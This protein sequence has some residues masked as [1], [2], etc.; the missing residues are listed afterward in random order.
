M[1]GLG[2]GIGPV[3]GGWLLEHFGWTAVFLVNVPIVVAVA[4]RR[5]RSWCPT[6]SD[7]SKARLDPLGAVLSTVGLGVLTAA[8]IEA[9]ERGW[10]AALVLG[11]L[12][13]GSRGARGL[14]GLGAPHARPRCSTCACSSVRR[15]SGASVSIALV[16]FSLFGAIYFLTQYLQGVMDYSALEAGLRVTPV[17]A[18]LILGGPLSAKLASRFGTRGVVAGGLTVVAVA[19]L[20][21]S[22]ADAD[23]GYGARRRLARAARA[24]AWAR[25]WLRPPSRS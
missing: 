12:R 6:R 25:R 22:G 15:F 13:A 3:I 8:I 19:L 14:R 11:G 23:S 24:S 18:G 17:A 16:F 1:A 20:L 21:L 2:V 9:P 7:P 10:T 4:R 5:R